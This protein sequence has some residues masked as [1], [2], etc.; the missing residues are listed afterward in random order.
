MNPAGLFLAR[1]NAAEVVLVIEEVE[2]D[3]KFDELELDVVEAAAELLV[4]EL[5]IG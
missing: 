5:L 4:D 1:W 2:E 3:D